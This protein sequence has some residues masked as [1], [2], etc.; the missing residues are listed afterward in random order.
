MRY[1]G[2]AAAA[3]R[4]AATPPPAEEPAPSLDLREVVLSTLAKMEEAIEAKDLA[5][6]RRVWTSL[7]DDDIRRLEGTFERATAIRVSLEIEEGSVRES[8]GRILVTVQTAYDMDMRRG[9]QQSYTLPQELEIGRRE[10][11][12]VVVGHR[13]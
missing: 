9:G 12:W 5:A 10:N 4:D 11:G 8:G 3:Y 2:L 1:L 7:S 13:D 6:L